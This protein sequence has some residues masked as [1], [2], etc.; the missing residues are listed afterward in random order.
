MAEGSEPISPAGEG[1]A[2][3]ASRGPHWFVV[4]PCIV[5]PCLALFLVSNGGWEVF[6]TVPVLLVLG[7]F[8]LGFSAVLA[9]EPQPLP[10]WIHYALGANL[11]SLVI[12]FL[13]SGG[14]GDGDSFMLLDHA[15]FHLG[16]TFLASPGFQFG[17]CVFWILSW[18][19][20]LLCAWDRRRTAKRAGGV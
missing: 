15:G 7:L 13:F 9:R 12:P 6:F 10:D 4:A 17:A 11:V 14:K 3:A 19:V 2:A 1:K 5:V 16:H 18:I 20:L 8:Q